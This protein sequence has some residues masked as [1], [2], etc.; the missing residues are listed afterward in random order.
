MT[1]EK[2]VEESLRQEPNA[3]AEQLDG[4]TLSRLRQARARAVA[5]ARASWHSWLD[6]PGWALPAG[7]LAATTAL[8][9][10]LTMIQPWEAGDRESVILPAIP[11]SLLEISSSDVDL[12]LIEE[13]DFY[14][15]LA[16]ADIDEDP[17]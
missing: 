8:A 13:M 2:P 16:V 14:D 15:W 11:P 1:D 3:R 4:V 7:G 6:G 17:A 5:G 9:L 12:E 10:G